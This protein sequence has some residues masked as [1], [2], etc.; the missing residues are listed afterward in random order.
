MLAYI[1][2]MND[3]NVLARKQKS[4]KQTLEESDV[5]LKSTKHPQFLIGSE[6]TNLVH[7][8]TQT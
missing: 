3:F 5:L 6:G 4:L 7:L 1:K 2:V 8:V